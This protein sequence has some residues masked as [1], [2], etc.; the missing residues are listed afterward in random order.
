MPAPDRFIASCKSWDDF[1]ERATTLSAAE[2]GA[3]FERL[4]QLYLQVAPEYRTELQHVWLLR[5]VPVEIRQRLN[6]P[7]PD[8]GIDL[9]ARTRRGE[10]WAIQSKFRSQ[11]DRPLN[12]RELGTFSSLAFNTCNNIA[13]AVV[14]HTATKPVSKR[15]LM[16]NTVEIG[17]DRWQG[18]ETDVW[19]LIVGRVKGR[20]ARPKARDPRPHQRGAI[21]AAKAY[22]LRDKATRGRLIMPCGTG[23]SLA[24]YWIAEAL[25]ANTILV[26]VPSL[27]LLRQSVTDWT[28]EFLAHDKVPDWICVCSD[29]TVGNLER[30]EFVGEVYELGLPTHT[31]PKEIAHLLR[32]SSKGPKIVFTTYQSSD[33]LAAAAR[34]AR[35]K[36]D[37]AI[38][39]E[40][41]KTVGVRSKRFATLLRD[42]RVKIRCRLFMT[43]TERVF[44]GNNDDVLSM[45]NERDYG[46]CFSQ[47][48]YKAAITQGIISDYKIVTVTVSK[49]RVRRLIEKNRILN[50]SLRNLDEAAA[51]SVA[52]GIALK[53]VFKKH[54][55]KHAI[56][57]HRSI[58]AADRFREQQD[59]VNFLH[60]VGPRTANF[61]ISSKKT[62]GERSHLLRE[63]VSRK[64]SLMTNARCL[65]EGVDVPAIDCVV[66]TDPKQSRI[67][68]VQAAGR[69]LRRYPGKAYGYILLPLIVPPRIKFED[70][71]ETT[72]FRQVASTITALSTQDERIAE[73]FRAIEKGRLSSGKIIEIEGDVPVGM[74]I[75]IGEFAESIS[76]RVWE[77]VG[78]ANWRRFEDARTFVWGLGLKSEIEWRA[79]RS[80]SKKPPDIP[81]NPN[82]AYAGAGW[83]GMGDW[84]GTGRVADQ[85]REYRSF[86]KARAFAR[87]LDL[88]SKSQWDHY[89]KSGKKPDDVPTNADQSYAD[90]G[91]AGWGDWLGTETVATVL[92]QYRPFKE[93]RAFVRN[94]GLKSTPEWDKYCQS[95]KKRDNI[96][97][98]PKRTYAGAGWAGMG[99]WLGTGTVAS[100]LRQYRSFKEARAFARSL[101]LKS[102][103]DWEGYSR[104][105]KKPTDIPVNPQRTYAKNG[106]VGWGDWLG[107]GRVAD[108]LREYRSFKKARAF[109]R[110]LGL[111]SRA[112]WIR[113]CK[114]GKKPPDISTSPHKTYAED[115][116]AGWGDWLGT[117]NIA[118]RWHQYWP[119]KKA[120]AFARSLGLES[121]AEWINYCKFVTKPADLP[122]SP[123]HVYR[124]AGWAGYGD[125]LGTGRVADHLREYRSFKKARA[126]TRSLG[127]KSKS[128][129]EGYCRSGKKPT[130]IPT[131]PHQ[132]YSEK[133]W[134]GIGDWLGYAHS[135]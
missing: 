60:D 9:I 132:T 74:R 95:G 5:H 79:Y 13:L 80:S 21:S 88:K 121:Q 38:L 110:G 109:A 53:K 16:R 117:G 36:F 58:R 99:D 96:P 131:A 85:L 102:K 86:K 56:S 22:F 119:F 128:D 3:A 31:D 43:A 115:G 6:L 41:H 97:A 116:W 84:L 4:V 32:A 105:G 64:L 93:A 49:D 82:L 114:A 113:Y 42:N 122:A 125:W 103:S 17:L 63:F 78:R 81:T 124:G 69:A 90:A 45:D 7:G 130:D 100:F 106:W 34:R 50:L 35:I 44:R 8:E 54:R 1:W 14:A 133:G 48:S 129:W 11:R 27:A 75:K 25:K 70:F 87:G 39:D 65:T 120:R 19:A 67:D 62:A 2:K 112:E 33:K 18:I 26:A 20:S 83:A 92:R 23:K 24:A 71:A 10:Y 68:I 127:L 47:M 94:L 134:A 72:A 46:K 89:C 61:H 59:A 29:E 118:P 104:S 66:F 37:L 77:A 111:K 126:F 123:S 98:I 12:R 135:R 91:W 28:R 15:H 107:T 30:D 76:T 57:F 52:T 40:A 108:Q 55:I 51:Q 101:G 73:E